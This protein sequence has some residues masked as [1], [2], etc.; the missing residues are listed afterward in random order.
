MLTPFAKYGTKYNVI[1]NAICIHT[2]VTKF[3]KIGQFS[4]ES[5][6][7]KDG[8]AHNETTTNFVLF[9]VR[10]NQNE[11]ARISRDFLCRPGKIDVLISI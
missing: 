4:L 3:G 6:C 1:E 11:Q 10:R 8:K 7:I 9:F 2:R 5:Q